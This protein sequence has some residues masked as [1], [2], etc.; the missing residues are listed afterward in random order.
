MHMG[1]NG[2]IQSQQTYAPLKSLLG[3]YTVSLDWGKLHPKGFEES[4]L[5]LRHRC[6]KIILKCMRDSVVGEE[7]DF[8]LML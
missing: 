5:N 8:L 2:W 1:S 7:L 3:F 6:L 4:K